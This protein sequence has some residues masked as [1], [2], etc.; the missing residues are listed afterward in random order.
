MPDNKDEL[1]KQQNEEIQKLKKELKA[2]TK[3]SSML[4]VLKSAVRRNVHD[5]FIREDKIKSVQEENKKLKKELEETKEERDKTSAQ[6]FAAINLGSDNQE[7]T[8]FEEGGTPDDTCD[9]P[10]FPQTAEE[11][12]REYFGPVDLAALA[13]QLYPDQSMQHQNPEPESSAPPKIK[14]APIIQEQPDSSVKNEKKPADNI[15]YEPGPSGSTLHTGSNPRSKSGNEGVKPELSKEKS[16]KQD[17]LDNPPSELEDGP[18]QE[19]I[20]EAPFE[21][22]L[23]DL[24]EL[25]EDLP[26]ISGGSVWDMEEPQTEPEAI[27]VEHT[28]EPAD[29]SL[30]K[31]LKEFP[32]EPPKKTQKKPTKEP[33]LSLTKAE[34]KPK[35]TLKSQEKKIEKSD[36]GQKTTEKQ[37]AAEQQNQ[38]EKIKEKQTEPPKSKPQQN[39]NPTATVID[40][41]GKK[42]SKKDK[43]KTQQQRQEPEIKQEPPKIIPMEQPPKE[44]E[45]PDD[46]G[47]VMEPEEP[48]P[49]ELPDPNENNRNIFDEIFNSDS[50]NWDDSNI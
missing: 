50:D 40:K 38:P 14:D 7:Q 4:S 2:A 33:S 11:A 31:S 37:D 13:R 24:T 29:E 23:P 28:E 45:L 19:D 12:V 20:N 26:D 39:E 36:S 46:F 25:P 6:L 49:I 32:K 8:S 22:D 17:L 48:E 5:F 16:T 10:V 30:K 35:Q 21:D 42:K 1:L 47:I 18:M 9:A 43:R 15:V 41:N 44:V 3:P 27:Q 34:E